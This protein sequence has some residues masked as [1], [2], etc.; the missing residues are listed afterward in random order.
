MLTKRNVDNK[1]SQD[2]IKEM[3]VMVQRTKH[4]GR[5]SNGKSI[6]YWSNAPL[7]ESETTKHTQ[8]NDNNAIKFRGSFQT[9]EPIAVTLG[10]DSLLEENP[11]AALENIAAAAIVHTTIGK[12]A[13]NDIRL[14]AIDPLEPEAQ[15]H[16]DSLAVEGSLVESRVPAP[17]MIPSSVGLTT[18]LPDDLSSIKAEDSPSATVAM[19][20]TAALAAEPLE[21]DIIRPTTEE[22]VDPLSPSHRLDEEGPE[23]ANDDDELETDAA[24]RTI[25]VSVSSSISSVSQSSNAARP[26]A[27]EEAPKKVNTPVSSFV[28]AAPQSSGNFLPIDNKVAKPLPDGQTLPST[29][30][31]AV[32]EEPLDYDYS[33]MELP[34]SLPNLE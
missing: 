33:N 8:F 26:G 7:L 18:D 12:L 13:K 9:E 4:R 27:K 20:A 23:I 6:L 29:P 10:P 2:A 5:L 11:L 19:V 16:Q 28:P 34:P 32:E 25:E 22:P 21:E 31:A 3:Q 24:E 14:D 30:L 17:S 1:K 15:D